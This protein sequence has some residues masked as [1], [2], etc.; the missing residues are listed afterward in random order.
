MGII[1]KA[2][3]C[4]EL[5]ARMISTQYWAQNNAQGKRW[6][7]DDTCIINTLEGYDSKEE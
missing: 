1:D 3:F 5:V 4:D 7:K 2:Y 6:M